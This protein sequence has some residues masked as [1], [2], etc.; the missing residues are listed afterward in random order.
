MRWYS[1]RR[2]RRLL[3]GAIGHEEDVASTLLSEPCFSPG[4]HNLC[5]IVLT[6]SAELQTIDPI[7]DW[8]KYIT[9]HRRMSETFIGLLW[10][11]IRELDVKK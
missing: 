3:R 8:K 1:R 11:A 10:R 9:L 7:T 4:T 2:L 6:L 5:D